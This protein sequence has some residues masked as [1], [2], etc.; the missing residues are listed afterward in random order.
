MPATADAGAQKAA[1]HYAKRKAEGRCCRHG[2]HSLPGTRR[3]GKVYAYCQYHR[4]EFRRRMRGWRP[5]AR[6]PT[7]SETYVITPAPEAQAAFPRPAMERRGL[8]L[9]NDPVWKARLGGVLKRETQEQQRLEQQ[10]AERD[11]HNR[12]EKRGR[13][14]D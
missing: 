12:N 11:E 5:P 8:A 1:R 10:R 4:G 6:R 2:C 13:R 9:A 14:N 7:P 3:D